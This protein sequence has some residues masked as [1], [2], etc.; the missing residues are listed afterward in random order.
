MK[1]ALFIP[2]ENPVS[3]SILEPV[4]NELKQR[5]YR[6]IFLSM[7]KLYPYGTEQVLKNMGQDYA[8]ID[9]GEPIFERN[10]IR[11]L[12][13]YWKIRVW[14]KKF[15]RRLKPAVIV[16]LKNTGIP[17]L[18]IIAAKEQKIPVLFVEEP[19][20]FVPKTYIFKSFFSLTRLGY[21][22]RYIIKR[23]SALLPPPFDFL[24]LFEYRL[25]LVRCD[26]YAIKGRLWLGK[27][28]GYGIPRSRIFITGSPAYEHLKKCSP[29]H[30]NVNAFP[31]EIRTLLDSKIV[32]FTQAPLYR[33]GG[34]SKEDENRIY[35]NVIEACSKLQDVELVF[36]V[37]PRESID[38]IKSRIQ[39]MGLDEK[40][41]HIYKGGT[42]E[43][44]LPFCSAM[45]TAGST[46]FFFSLAFDIP[47]ILIDWPEF[48]FTSGFPEK[49]INISKKPEDTLKL[50]KKMLFNKSLRKQ[51]INNGKNLLEQLL[52]K[53]DGQSA[54]RIAELA[55][56]LAS[57]KTRRT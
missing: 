44:I 17:G 18:F 49:G 23:A 14:A 37:H 57:I 36:R 40:A 1:T 42:I 5:G 24:K 3:I 13:V 52:Y 55:D 41:C 56:R 21:L 8:P 32:L 29:D 2:A 39:A 12:K 33:G 47:T 9:E 20:S 22:F 54:Q 25:G 27:F 46:S 45:I 48:Y 4:T 30:S 35:R 31:N 43:Q 38:Y 6:T 50:L 16:T 28:L 7:E 15:I 19:F 10:R 26:A 53:R 51:M 11:Y 34:C